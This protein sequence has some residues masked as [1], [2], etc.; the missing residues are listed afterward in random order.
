MD[1]L[2][3]SP[4]HALPQ[5]M[6][7]LH[8]TLM[9]RPDLSSIELL[10]DVCPPSIEAPGQGGH[11][12]RSLAALLEF[13]LVTSDEN[14]LL[15][16]EQVPDVGS[17]IRL[18]R[19]SVV[20]SPSDV[21]PDIAGAPDLRRGLIWLM[22]QSPLNPLAWEENVQTQPTSPFV[23]DTRWIGFRAWAGVLGFSQTAIGDLYPDKAG[24]GKVRIVPNP[25]AAVVDAI[26]RPFGAPLPTG[27]PI[28]I[29][30]LLTHIRSEIPVF[31][32]HPTAVYDG[33]SAKEDDMG[34][35]LA[36]ALASAEFRGLLKMTYESDTSGA[37]AL[38]DSAAP[39]KP[40]YVSTVT[41]GTEHK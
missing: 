34:P 2:N 39:M 7:L 27:Q 29:T 28:P 14:G 12:R 41:I 36:Y 6:W 30:Q 33:L 25:T 38:P 13:G 5:T 22:R 23:N 4:S 19:R 32:G 21:S 37:T 18:L 40:R 3:P 35:A 31:P 8:K 10:E 1:V 9:A 17:F 15:R 26:G 11:V 20:V 24:R 16:A